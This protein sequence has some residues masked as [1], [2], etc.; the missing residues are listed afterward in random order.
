M[1]QRER[2]SEGSFYIPPSVLDKAEES[3][4]EG[5]KVQVLEP[6]IL[7][8]I[9]PFFNAVIQRDGAFSSS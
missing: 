5:K 1:F 9:I 4:S 8:H 7:V 6:Y 2:D 3:I